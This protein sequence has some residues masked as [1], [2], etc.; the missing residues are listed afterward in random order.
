MQLSI[1]YC[2]SRWRLLVHSQKMFLSLRVPCNSQLSQLWINSVVGN[3]PLDK[4]SIVFLETFMYSVKLVTR[5]MKLYHVKSLHTFALHT[6]ATTVMMNIGQTFAIISCIPCLI[7]QIIV[8]QL[9]IS[10]S[11]KRLSVTQ[12]RINVFNHVV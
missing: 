3:P 4:I 5:I 12:N 1:Y 7:G 9:N 6:F 11:L 2:I 10:L 8:P